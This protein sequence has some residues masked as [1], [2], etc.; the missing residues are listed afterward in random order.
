M[1]EKLNIF[2]I[3]LVMGA[4]EVVPG[5]SGGTI[6]FITGIYER[7]LTSLKHFTPRLLLV[8]KDEGFLAVWRRVDAEF[9]LLLFGGMGTS[10]VLFATG[11]SYLLTHQPIVLWSFFFGLVLASSWLMIRQIDGLN[12]NRAAWAVAGIAIGVVI[13]GLAP[14]ALAPTPLFIFLGGAVAVCA[15]ILPG[16][17]GSFILLILG[18]YG[19]VIEAI[20]QLDVSTLLFLAAGCGLGLISFAQVLS[21]LFKH[22]RDETLAILTGFMLG[23][24]IKLW[25]WKQTLAYQ[26]GSDGHQIPLVQEPVLPSTYVLITGLESQLGL[27]LVALLVGV[28]AVV[29]LEKL[30]FTRNR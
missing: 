25:P 18:L 5:V 2:I 9:L 27:A 12:L 21:R 19:F 23:S 20:K 29:G 11:I 3:G 30:A 15:W 26:L 8:L 4:A 22:R 6:A 17:S 16:I 7:L 14:I 1:K 28:V 10:I 24:L 13:T